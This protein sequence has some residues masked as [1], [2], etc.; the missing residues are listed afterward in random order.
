[1]NHRKKATNALFN[2][3]PFPPEDD[4]ERCLIFSIPNS[5]EWELLFR[6]LLGVGA[7]WMNYVPSGTDHESKVA[8]KVREWLVSDQ[9]CCDWVY[10]CITGDERIREW[11]DENYGDQGEPPAQSIR[12]T[13]TGQLDCVWGGCVSIVNH[14]AS[15]LS[16]ILDAIDSA[17]AAAEQLEQFLGGTKWIPTRLVPLLD[18]IQ[19]FAN[20]GTALIR[21][22]ITQE[23]QDNLSCDLFCLIRYAGQPYVLTTELFQEWLDLYPLFPNGISLGA[24]FRLGWQALPV[25]PVGGPAIYFTAMSTIQAF[26]YYVLGLN[27]CSNDWQV[28]C[29]ACPTKWSITWDVSS[30]SN[31]SIVD[32]NIGPGGEIETEYKQGSGGDY[33]VRAV[34]FYRPGTNFIVTGAAIEGEILRGRW[35][36]GTDNALSLEADGYQHRFLEYNDLTEGVLTP[37]NFDEPDLT[38]RPT[39]EAGIT[40]RASR[41]GTSYTTRRGGANITRIVI[42]GEGPAPNDLKG[43]TFQTVIP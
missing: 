15:E 37:I 25:G 33:A 7:T 18:I 4:G 41:R 23:Q 12:D 11:F 10:Q 21:A 9:S 24:C 26:K 6:S 1:M 14:M 28:L 3:P 30:L 35:S 38:E 16:A 17:L 20:V 5:D 36:G 42:Y 31:L 29:D 27:N 8:R 39:T 2:A 32:G 19:T 22:Q 13:E 34:I 40:I 43:G